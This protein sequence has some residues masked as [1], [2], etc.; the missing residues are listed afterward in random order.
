MDARE[1]LESAL[2]SGEYRFRQASVCGWLRRHSD[3]ENRLLRGTIVRWFVH[4]ARTDV[5]W[6]RQ[7]HYRDTQLGMDLE[8]QLAAL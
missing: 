8:D 4:T 3:L 1:R 6:G 5:R 7:A 2:H